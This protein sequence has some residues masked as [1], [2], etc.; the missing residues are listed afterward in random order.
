MYDLPLVYGIRDKLQNYNGIVTYTVLSAVLPMFFLA[1]DM[2]LAKVTF[3]RNHF[4]F[5]LVFVT[6]YEILCIAG[7]NDIGFGF[8]YRIWVKQKND[9]NFP[10]LNSVIGIISGILGHD[11]LY[12]LTFLAGYS[13]HNAFKTKIVVRT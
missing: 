8:V 4:I 1:A 9:E 6:G 5:A 10:S 12:M 13:L 3:V 7:K 11:L 2:A